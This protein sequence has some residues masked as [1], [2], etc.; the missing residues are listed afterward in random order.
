MDEMAT[1]WHYG[2]VALSVMTAIVGS[3]VALGFAGRLRVSFGKKRIFWT[4]MGAMT[5]GLAIWSMHFVGMM[6]MSIDMPMSYDPTLS[7]L[8]MIAADVGAGIAF[9]ILQRSSIDR[10]H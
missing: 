7:F 1:T 6:A 5:M 9:I 10:I 2:I 8:S 4:L 3:Y